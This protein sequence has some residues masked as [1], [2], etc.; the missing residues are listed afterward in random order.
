MAQRRPFVLPISRKMRQAWCIRGENWAT[1]HSQWAVWLTSFGLFY[2]V[3]AKPDVRPEM[4]GVCGAMTEVTPPISDAHHTPKSPAISFEFFP[5][6]TEEMERN[7][8]ETIKRLAP[9]AACIGSVT[10]GAGGSTRERT[11]ST[12]TRI[13]PETSR[14]PA[15]HL[16][17]GGAARGEADD[18]VAR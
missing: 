8:W 7:L 6:K 5:P 14:R 4:R 15:A 11:H 17:W 18:I 2:R 13:L 9:L 3:A 10:Y 12:I 1:S 16:A